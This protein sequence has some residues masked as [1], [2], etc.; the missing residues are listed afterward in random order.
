MA[1]TVDAMQSFFRRRTQEDKGEAE[2]EGYAEYYRHVLGAVDS[3]ADWSDPR[4][5]FWSMQATTDD[6]A[7]AA[8]I[9]V[10]ATITL[11]CLMKRSKSAISLKRTVTV[12][13]AFIGL[14]HHSIASASLPASSREHD[15]PGRLSRL[16]LFR[17]VLSAR[18]QAM[19]ERE[20]SSPTE[21][22]KARPLNQK[23]R[24]RARRPEAAI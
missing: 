24:Q 10:H 8:E 1:K 9:A 17:Y 5:A 20:L 12:S 14:P 16:Q 3:F 11:P 23:P 2:D 15:F 18:L 19:A 6:S 7:F 22:Q 4:Q 21:K 13:P